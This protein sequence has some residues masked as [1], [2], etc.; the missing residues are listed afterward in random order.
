MEVAHSKAQQSGN[1]LALAALVRDCGE[2]N[3]FS[4]FLGEMEVGLMNEETKK[5]KKIYK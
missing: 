5:K 4:K 3:P 2:R 1:G